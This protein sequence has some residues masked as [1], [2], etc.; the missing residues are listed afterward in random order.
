MKIPPKIN[1]LGTSGTA[2]TLYP[3][4]KVTNPNLKIP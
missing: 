1:Y 3:T 2:V 4:R